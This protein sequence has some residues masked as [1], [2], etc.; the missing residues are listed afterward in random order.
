DQG[1]PIWRNKVGRGGIQGGVHFGMALEG[2]TL[3]VPISDMSNPEAETNL[4]AVPSKA[5]LYAVDID[6]GRMLWSQPAN[7][8]CNGRTYCEPGISAAITA[9]PGAVL[10]GH[11]DGRLRAYDSV[12]GRVIWEYD[13]TREVVTVDGSKASGGSFGG[14]AG[15][16]VQDGMLFA[17]SGYGTYFHM[18]GNVLLVFGLPE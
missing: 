10:A 15:P 1:R 4:H 12:T 16:V 11:M 9:V 5:G 13:T 7:N 8:I 2:K 3:F 6:T 14:G 18:P 17:A